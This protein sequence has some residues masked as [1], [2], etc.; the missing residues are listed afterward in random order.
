VQQAATG[1]QRRPAKVRVARENPRSTRTRSLRSPK[2]APAAVKPA[3]RASPPVNRSVAPAGPAARPAETRLAVDREHAPPSGVRI[4]DEPLARWV[5][6]VA[7]GVVIVTLLL[8]GA[9][10]WA[11]RRVLKL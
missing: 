6:F 3:R 9:G 10:V 11:K 8:L 4:L 1:A 7:G 5:A 2:P